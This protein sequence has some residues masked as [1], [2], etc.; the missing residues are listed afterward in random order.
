MVRALPAHEPSRARLIEL[1]ETVLANA[2]KR[3]KRP[4]A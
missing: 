3:A 1:I 2:D 4:A